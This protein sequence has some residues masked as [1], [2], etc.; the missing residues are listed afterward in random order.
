ME[1]DLEPSVPADSGAL[2]ELRVLEAPVLSIVR[3]PEPAP[4]AEIPR[5][6]YRVQLNKSFTF[7]DVTAI[8]PYLASLGISHVYCSPYFKSRAGSVHGYDVVDHNQLNPE[9]GTREDFETFV[10]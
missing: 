3:D 8:I 1:A 4:G 6:T 9:I 2:D 5:A 7:K 10:A